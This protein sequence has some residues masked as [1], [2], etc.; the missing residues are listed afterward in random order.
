MYRQCQGVF[1]TV[2][3]LGGLTACL[4][5]P[6]AGVSS[7]KPPKVLFD[8]AMSAAERHHYDVANM[9][10]QTL[11]NT[12]PDSE[13]AKRAERV[14]EGPR[15]APCGVSGNMVFFSNPPSTSR[16]DCASTSPDEPEF[17]PP[18]DLE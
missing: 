11:V 17:L 10:L 3:R 12:Y 6:D 2:A 16:A 14:L 5:W 7:K 8:Q 4:N 13:Y 18:P 1:L 9:T 15:I